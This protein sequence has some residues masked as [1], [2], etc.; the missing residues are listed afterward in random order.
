MS[1][2]ARGL[3]YTLRL[4]C[5]ENHRMPAELSTLSAVLRAEISSSTF[6]QVLPFFETKDGWLHCPELDNYRDYL[7]DRRLKQSKGGKRGAEKTNQSRPSRKGGE[8][9]VT[10]TPTGKPT[11]KLTGPPRVNLRALS[12]E[13]SSAVQLNT[14]Q[15]SN[16]DKQNSRYT[17]ET[18]IDQLD[19][20]LATSKA[21]PD[22]CPKCGGEGCDWCDPDDPPRLLNTRSDRR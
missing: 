5:W 19:H 17:Y 13:Q 6:E 8:G 1:L 18:E 2:E 7:E 9:K 16:H 3:L 11:G 10:G 22:F 4:E 14:K 21:V 15:L 20:D 12:K